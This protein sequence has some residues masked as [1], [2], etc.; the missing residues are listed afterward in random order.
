M[1]VAPVEASS[2]R[3]ISAYFPTVRVAPD[4]YAFRGLE[5]GLDIHA[6][7]GI[8]ETDRDRVLN[9]ARKADIAVIPDGR[10]L[11][12]YFPYPVNAVLGDV[13]QRLRKDTNVVERTPVDLPDGAM[14]IF[15]RRP[16][17]IPT[18]VS[19]TPSSGSAASQTFALQYSDTAGVANLQ[20]VWA[21][22]T[23]SSSGSSSNVCLVLYYPAP[24]QINLLN[25][26]KT[27]WQTATPGASTTLQNS[28]CSLN[29]AATTVARNDNTLTMNPAMTFRPTYAGSKNISMYAADV[30]GSNSGWQKRGTWT[31][32]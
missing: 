18:T 15:R 7:H 3:H 31:V 19:V 11:A 10:L 4:A 24:N 29:V 12:E 8:M 17:G 21:Y 5:E 16:D 6:E 14:L 26:N 25:D 2:S 20:S 28:Q 22:F 32:P 23:T 9:S 30:S 13:V 27:T 1:T